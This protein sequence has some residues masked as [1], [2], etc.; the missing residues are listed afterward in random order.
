MSGASRKGRPSTGSATD[1]THSRCRNHPTRRAVISE[2]RG[3]EPMV[4][5]CQECFEHSLAEHR[6]VFDKLARTL[7]ERARVLLIG[8]LIAGS[9][10]VAGCPLR[11]VPVTGPMNDCRKVQLPSGEVILV[12]PGCYMVR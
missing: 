3:D 11:I 4:D 12:P 5:L 8:A 1:G 2:K 10:L 7:G 6:Q 9:L